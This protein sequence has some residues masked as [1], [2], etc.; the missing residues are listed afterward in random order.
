MATT[1]MAEPPPQATNNN[2]MDSST[3]S[4]NAPGRGGGQRRR[5]GGRGRGGGGGRGRGAERRQP[6]PPRTESQ[7]Q[8]Q[9]PAGQETSGQPPPSSNV[10]ADAANAKRNRRRPRRRGRGGAGRGDDA[11]GEDI[12]GGGA[13]QQGGGAGRRNV[14]A[15]AAN[16]KRNRRRPRRR[17]RGGA[18]RGDDAGEDIGGGGAAQ[19]GAQGG[20][21]AEAPPSPRTEQAMAFIADSLDGA[22][23]DTFNGN[24]QQRQQ[25]SKQRNKKKGKNGQGQG[26]GNNNN[27]SSNDSEAANIDSQ[28]GTFSSQQQQSADGEKKKKKR[29][30][31][32][33][34]RKKNNKSQPWKEFIPEG[35]EDPISLQPL[36]DLPYPPFVIVVDSPYIPVMPGMWPPPKEADAIPSAE[37]ENAPV[38]K[39]PAKSNSANDKEREM[40]I[41]KEQWGEGVKVVNTADTPAGTNAKTNEG[42]DASP[43]NN[44][45]TLQNRHFNLFDGRVLAYYLVSTLQFIDPLTR[46][47]LTRPELLALDAYLAHHDLGNAGVTEAYDAKG[48]TVSTAGS[49]AQSAAG[50]A[51][52]LQQEARAIMSSFRMGVGG[53]GGGG[54]GG[55]AH[56]GKQQSRRSGN[57]PSTVKVPKDPVKVPKDPFLE[58]QQQQQQQQQRSRQRERRDVRRVQSM[59]SLT[60]ETSGNSFQ[61]MYAAQRGGRANATAQEENYEPGAADTGIYGGDDGGMVIID[62]DINPGLRSGVPTTSSGDG[63]SGNGT[64][65]SARHIA[66]QHSQVAQAREGNFP[67]LPSATTAPASTTVPGTEPRD[68]A[69]AAKGGASKSLSKISNLVKKTNPKELER[70]R[71]A[72]E[73]AQ[74]RAELAKLSFF[75]PE[76]ALATGT[77]WGNATQQPAAAAAAAPEQ[78]G[79]PSEAVIERNRNLAMALGVAP[80]TVRNTEQM[81]TSGWARPVTTPALTNDEFGNELLVNAANYSEALLAEA[82][83]RMTELIKL[84]KQWKKFLM[85][86]RAASCSLKAMDRPSRK[87]VHEY[88]DFWRLKTESF[89]PE[90]R[91]YIQCGK[92]VDTC[93]PYPLLSEAARKWRGPNAATAGTAIGFGGMTTIALPTGPASRP[94]ATAPVVPPSN[95]GW[96]CP[97]TEQ[98]VPLKLVPRTITEISAKTNNNNTTAPPPIPASIPASAIGGGMTRSTSTPLLSMTNEHP[99][100]PRFA[101]LHDKERPRLQL[102]PR[103]IPTWDELEKRHIS[104]EE[105]N[106][107]APDRQEDILRDIEEEANRKRVAEE[108][109]REKEEARVARLEIKARKKDAQVKKERAILESAFASSD[110]DDDGNSSGSD[111][112]EGDLEFDGSDDEGL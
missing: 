3:S 75:N 87:F 11:A 47:D 48:V 37:G 39:V 90:G 38:Q 76:T 25:Q 107:M 72:R 40:A 112:F 6:Q 5:R 66:E 86:D 44:T 99:P 65:Y 53:G 50:R 93:A 41:L 29:N 22:T 30:R 111:W 12:G 54:G 2:P 79:P 34:N 23:G 94:T 60:E 51:E 97:T 26:Q 1:V 109:E 110:E 9:Q 32:N 92:L 55:G 64:F 102:A 84:E 45:H 14:G 85:D 15:D 20:S 108:R 49:A 36:T 27:N 106:S 16:A 100:P 105:W 19:Q 89:D 24:G 52:I 18:G 8:P 68:A 42:P 28:D 71:K 73:E 69:A 81:L 74:R 95:D 33:R 43:S 78:K 67:S 57:D 21:S 104:Q 70:Q 46:R 83:E 35:L 13:A 96:R 58:R 88:S 4:S 63:T 98:R 61:R 101:D 56:R 62:D 31:K 82:R 10:G 77:R 103:S 80:S 7:P 59:G 91:R 17:G